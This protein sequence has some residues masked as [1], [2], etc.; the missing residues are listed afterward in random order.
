MN[1][2]AVTTG[3]FVL[4][5]CGRRS[6]AACRCG[7]PMCAEH[8]GPQGLCPECEGAQNYGDP[9]HPGWA[10]GFRRLFYR[11]SSQRYG[12]TGWYDGFDT[13]DRGS[14]DVGG[15]VDYGDGGGDGNDWV[16]S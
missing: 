11:Q 10:Q 13:Y 9:Y 5:R 2:C 8:A 12:D 6:V 15:D 3:F 7:R 14:F 1:P 4:G 16:D